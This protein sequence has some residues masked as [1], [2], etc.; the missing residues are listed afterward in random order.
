MFARINHIGLL[1]TDLEKSRTFYGTVLGLKELPRPKFLTDGIW[2]DVG[3]F[4]LH[5]MLYEKQKQPHFHP[6]NE[7]VQPHF[8]IE[9]PKKE[10]LIIIGNLQ[11]HG[12]NLINVPLE[13]RNGTSQI[14]FYDFDG[15]MIEI[16]QSKP[17]SN[18]T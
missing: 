12:V 14:F 1:T 4:Q 5:L 18:V 15:N 11:E 10:F 13:S 2:Y 16:C 9:L 7:T 3:T 8:S 6:L 17:D